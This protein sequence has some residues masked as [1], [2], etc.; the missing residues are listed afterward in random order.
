MH[1]PTTRSR[2]RPRRPVCMSR[3]LLVLAGLLST[4]TL[5]AP[6]VALAAS[7]TSGPPAGLISWYKADGNA[8][9]SVGH[10]NGTTH[11]GV[12]YAAG[13]PG[14]AFSFNGSTGYVSVGDPIDLRS[15][16]KNFTIAARVWFTSNSS[17][18]GSPSQP[19]HADGGP[20][21]DMSIVT[22]MAAGS[23]PNSNG[24]R[25]VKQSDNHIWFCFGAN[26][27][28][29]VAGSDTTA[30]STTAVVPDRWYEVVGVY[31][32]TSGISIYVNG[33]LQDRVS[34]AGA[35]DNDAA[36]M[37]FGYYPGESF[38]WGRLNQIQYF[39]T[40]LTAAQI[41]LLPN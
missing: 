6:G 24:W 15:D 33:K 35:V 16:G 7:K 4:C 21:C 8:K 38:L 39:D 3:R 18:A 25:L 34:G 30:I 23:T 17:P 9:D 36:S 31:S 28:G 2:V 11:G 29:C 13:D 41:I 26:G 22:K 32:K 14:E 12:T 40:S 5:L 19:C 10:N 1:L 20:G 37:L 27:N